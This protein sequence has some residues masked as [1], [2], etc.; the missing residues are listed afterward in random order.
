MSFVADRV[1]ETAPNPGAGAVTPGGAV[2]GYQS[3]SAAVPTG[4]IVTIAI[5]S[6]TPGDWEV[7]D[8]TWDGTTLTRGDISGSSTGSRV[9]FTSTV[10]VFLTPSARSLRGTRSGTA[11]LLAAKNFGIT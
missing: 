2:S 8:A 10:N 3:F 7:C 6:S 5:E 4:S 9:T 11:Q 1:S